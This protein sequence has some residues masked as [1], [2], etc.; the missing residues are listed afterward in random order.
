[1]QTAVELICVLQARH[2]TS[3]HISIAKPAHCQANPSQE[4]QKSEH[5]NADNAA[6]YLKRCNSAKE[7]VTKLECS[8]SK[9]GQLTEG[10]PSPFAQTTAPVL[11][12]NTRRRNAQRSKACVRL[13][14]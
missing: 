11:C 2:H 4:Q 1:M 8:G 14:D 13:I 7:K 5:F 6:D 9:R 10:S 3:G 12:V